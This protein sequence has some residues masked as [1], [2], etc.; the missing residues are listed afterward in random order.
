MGKVY[1]ARHALLR[2][3]TAVKLISGAHVDSATLDRFEHEVQLTSQLTHPNTIEVY[4]Y[5]HTQEGVFYYVMEY[6]PGIDL[7][8]LIE[9]ADGQFPPTGQHTSSARSAA[10]CKRPIP[11][12]SFTVTS[13]P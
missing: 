4:D 6:L 10:R 7:A 8:R 11:G 3:P 1:L 12:G 13:S 5:G 2:R 9:L